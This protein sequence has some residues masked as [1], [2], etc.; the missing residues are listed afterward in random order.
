MALVGPAGTG[1]TFGVVDFLHC[2]ARDNPRLRILFARATRASLTESVLVTYEQDVLPL[3]GMEAIAA[4]ALRRVRQSYR[5]PNG[6]EIVV[7]GLDNATRVLSTPWDFV[8]VNEAI[9]TTID[10]HETLLSRLRR[11]GR[12]SRFGYLLFDSNPGDP[13]H[14]IKRRIDA[15]QLLC[16]QTPHQANPRMWD[17]KAWTDEGREYLEQL[18]RLTGTR[19]KRLLLGQ[20][21]AGDAAW[22][23]E[24]DAA[25]HVDAE[26][27]Y[28]PNYPAYLSADHN[29][30]NRAAVWW[31]ERPGEMGEPRITVFADWFEDRPHIDA[32]ACAK[33]ILART[34]DF[35]A[36]ITSQWGDPAGSQRM[37]LNMTVASEYER[38]GLR[39]QPWPTY[40][41]SVVA[42]L[43]L[44][45]S[46][47]PSLR[48]HPRC[49]H[50]IAAIPN[51]R[52]KMRNKQY[53][54]EPEDPQH[55]HED[56]IDAFTGGLLARW[57][58]GRK[59]APKLMRRPATRVF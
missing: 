45:E 39:L 24:F 23:P 37:G 26:A 58:E 2:L 47:L 52:R 35:K 21:A 56:V 6:S 9:E 22:F 1:K 8:F 30:L 15:G 34:T 12:R 32:H 17:G 14:W 28:D 57:P 59:P 49:E 53:V 38:A 20:W 5:Y 16:W 41:G 54:D 13:S 4:G 7:G 3:D 11:P 40:P 55:P 46:F 31:Q 19:R 10:S 44:L 48:V 18:E 27:E 25:T 42:R 29:G 36:R 33:A 50:V 43:N 51:Y